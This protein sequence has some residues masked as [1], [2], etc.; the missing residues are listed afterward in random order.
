MIETMKMWQ[1]A[2]L[3]K[4][5][6]IASADGSLHLSTILIVVTS[7]YWFTKKIL[8]S[9]TLPQP[10]QCGTIE[11]K[12]PHISGTYD[13]TWNFCRNSNL[14]ESKK[15]SRFHL[16]YSSSLGQLPNQWVHALSF[17]L[18]F[19]LQP[20]NNQLRPI[21]FNKPVQKTMWSL[22]WLSNLSMGWTLRVFFLW[23]SLSKDSLASEEWH[24]INVHAWVC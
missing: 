11:I 22:K 24:F 15:K 6:G 3:E 16:L 1:P 7:N 2:H 12:C 14:R 17:V 9:S 5:T 18:V 21:D 23:K 10:M 4:A 19:E 8:T 20:W 13:W